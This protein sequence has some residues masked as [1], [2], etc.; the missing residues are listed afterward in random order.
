MVLIVPIARRNLISARPLA[1]LSGAAGAIA[2]V[3][4]SVQVAREDL[5]RGWLL[6]PLSLLPFDVSWRADDRINLREATLTASGDPSA[7]ENWP[8]AHSWNWIDEWLPLGGACGKPISG[9]LVFSCL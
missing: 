7:L 3:V 2:L 9:F 6:Y 1:W 8:V 4:G 5:L